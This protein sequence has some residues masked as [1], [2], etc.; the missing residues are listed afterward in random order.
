MKK[1]LSTSKS[2]MVLAGRGA[3]A[4]DMCGK[5]RARW[6]C[7]A[8][9]AYLC[10]RCDGSVHSA[11][12]LARRHERV[13]LGPNGAPTRTIRKRND[14]SMEE[15]EILASRKR[16]LGSKKRSKKADS[17]ASSQQSGAFHPPAVPITVLT[18]DTETC[19]LVNAKQEFAVATLLSKEEEK[20]ILQPT[21]D[22]HEEIIELPTNIVVKSEPSSPTID[23]RSA[24]GTSSDFF[25]F[26]MS[27]ESELAHEVPTYEPF[28]RE[29]IAA[30]HGDLMEE[31]VPTSSSLC[32]DTRTGWGDG[33]CK[34]E[35]LPDSSNAACEVDASV[36]EDGS[37][38]INDVSENDEFDVMDLCQGGK[39][40][41][42]I[43]QER[44]LPGMEMWRT[45]LDSEACSTFGG[46]PFK[47]K[48]E[49][50]LDMGFEKVEH[51]VQWA[52][53]DWNYHQTPAAFRKTLLQLNYEEVLMAWSDRG[54]LWMDGHRPQTVPDDSFFDHGN[55]D[56]G[57]HTE[58]SCNSSKAEDQAGQV[59]VVEMCS[60]T[61]MAREAR[62][63]R[64]REKRRTRFFSKKIRYEVRKLNAERRPRMKGRFVKL[65]TITTV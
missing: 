37:I 24:N 27:E 32:N 4:C 59:P 38:S 29:L 26:N 8:D 12:L 11:N 6:Y 36:V 17:R 28:L 30:S 39:Q 42:E 50:Q 55:L 65:S 33:A 7:A 51:P 46:N 15:Y 1:M 14:T 20:R 34:L 44:E 61:G 10:E 45:S 56:Y 18:D 58:S 52:N 43:S 63:M 5:E 48:G 40:E 35:T 9:E 49:R 64:Y 3:R 31:I 41:E 2:G 57:L 54:S 21:P 23:Y 60:E 62:V 22:A 47:G 19:V 25:D 53:S 13:K 16:H